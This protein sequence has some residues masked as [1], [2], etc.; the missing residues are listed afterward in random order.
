M[1][2]LN[3][4]TLNLED[5]LCNPKA[6]PTAATFSKKWQRWDRTASNTSSLLGFLFSFHIVCYLT[7]CIIFAIFFRSSC[8][9]IGSV[10]QVLKS[11]STQYGVNLAL[12]SLQEIVSA[13]R[14]LS[15]AAQLFRDVALAPDEERSADTKPT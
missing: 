15:P 2:C 8:Y 4:N 5:T 10:E 7:F 9:K 3:G 11:E 13:T 6:Y 14:P 12:F 1:S